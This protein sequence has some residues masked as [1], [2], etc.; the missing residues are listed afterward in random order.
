M[1]PPSGTGAARF[2]N[3]GAINDSD[4]ELSPKKSGWLFLD[5][6]FHNPYRHPTK[7]LSRSL[8]TLKQGHIG[9]RSDIAMFCSHHG[10]AQRTPVAQMDQ[11]GSEQG[12][13][14]FELTTSSQS[15]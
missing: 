12:L 3:R 10:L 15:P 11:K 8:E 14:I 13:R 7:P 5:P 9:N 4:P 6:A 2:L 1:N